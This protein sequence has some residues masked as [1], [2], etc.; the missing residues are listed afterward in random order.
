MGKIVISGKVKGNNDVVKVF[1]GYLN[2]E[3]VV[4]LCLL[5]PQISGW[6]KYFENG[7]KNMSFK[8]EE[9]WVYLKYNEIWNKIKGLLGIK[10]NNEPIYDDQY[11]KTKAKT[12]DNVVKTL[13]DGG[14]PKERVEY[15]C[16]SCIS[17]DS[18]LKVVKKWY[19]QVYLEQCK[20]KVKKREIKNFFDYEIDLS[21]DYESDYHI[22]F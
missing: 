20:C 6:I 16:I 9:D 1:I 3:S 17:V 12:F 5:L 10:F 11:I 13:F 7:G 21:S 14:I 19:P 22:C 15:T 2:E 18:V 4:P 8:I